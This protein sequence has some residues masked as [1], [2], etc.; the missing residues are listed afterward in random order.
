RL[1]VHRHALLD[2]ALARVRATASGAQ[3]AHKLYV[4][5][6]GA[7]KT[8]LI[9]L[10]HHRLAKER[11]TGLPIQISWLI[12]DPWDIETFE[13]LLEAILE[14]RT[15][16]VPDEQRGRNAEATVVASANAH[17]PIVVLVEN[18]D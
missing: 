6:R 14:S 11:A 13:D 1:F 17:G 16:P 18:L 2:D 9:S 12:E 4:G 3:R 7:G 10:L 5:P 8:H 15:E